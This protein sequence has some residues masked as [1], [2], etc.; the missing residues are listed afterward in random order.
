M[1]RAVDLQSILI[2]FNEVFASERD[3]PSHA[4]MLESAGVYFVRNG[5][6]LNAKCGS[7]LSANQQ[8]CW[9]N[10]DPK[11]DK[12]EFPPFLGLNAKRKTRV[13][14]VQFPLRFNKLEDLCLRSEMNRMDFFRMSCSS[15]TRS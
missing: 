8:P 3:P 10:L 7:M 2:Q 12:Q 1:K 5:S 11:F 4:R 13:D 9:Q 15:L 14:P 6:V